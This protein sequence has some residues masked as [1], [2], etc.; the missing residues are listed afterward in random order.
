[1]SK[2]P[3]DFSDVPWLTVA[4]WEEMRTAL[5]DD[6]ACLFGAYDGVPDWDRIIDHYD[7]LEEPLPTDWD[8][9]LIKA[10]KSA[11][12]QGKRGAG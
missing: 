10:M 2:Y 7:S 3:G 9:P 4:R 11:W 8:H 12:R 6:G 5:Y 1:M